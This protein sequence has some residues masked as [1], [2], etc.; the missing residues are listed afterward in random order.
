M[1]RPDFTLSGRRPKAPCPVCS[2]DQRT[3]GA[4]TGSCVASLCHAPCAFY[5]EH[6]Y[7]VLMR[8]WPLVC[9]TWLGTQEN[10]ADSL[11]QNSR[12]F[13]LQPSPKVPE[14][15]LG[16]VWRLA[17]PHCRG[18]WAPSRRQRLLGR[19]PGG[20]SLEFQ[21]RNDLD[22]KGVLFWGKDVLLDDLPLT[23]ERLWNTPRAVSVLGK[24]WSCSPGSLCGRKTE[25]AA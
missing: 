4:W 2:G 7:P 17:A 9:L 13:E 24:A 11:S 16:H 12:R 25:A 21:N 5:P 8:R 15:V 6:R 18:S 20:E 3:W 19:I 14:P 1:P 22:V 23:R 10:G